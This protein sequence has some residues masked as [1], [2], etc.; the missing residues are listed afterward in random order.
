MVDYYQDLKEL[1]EYLPP[2]VLKGGKTE[3]LLEGA[4]LATC[5]D[6]LGVGAIDRVF[7][8]GSGNYSILM[9]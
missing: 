7:D 6:K 9:I 3:Q 1:L 4:T 5:R 8:D 2:S